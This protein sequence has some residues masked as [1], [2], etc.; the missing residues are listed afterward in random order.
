M[1][2]LKKL[3]SFTL[4]KTETIITNI[5]TKEKVDT[6][7]LNKLLSSDLLLE[8]LN[9]KYEG[10][11]YKNELKQL[12]EYKQK[13][14]SDGFIY[15]D[16]HKKNVY[17]R[18]HSKT[19]S[20][21]QLRKEIRQ[22]I[23][24]DIYVDIDI[25]NCHVVLLQQICK[26]NKQ[27]TP[28]L[29]DYIK[30]RN[31]H[32]L[33][34]MTDYNVDRD[35]AKKVFLVATYCGDFLIEGKP[36]PEF[37][38]KLVKETR[39]IAKIV[40]EK[41]P[42][43]KQMVIQLEK[44]KGKPLTNLNGKV[45]SHYL[46][47]V[48]HVILN[49]MYIY[50]VDNKFI[51]N[52]DCSLQA[53]GIMIPAITYN[54]D[55]LKKMSVHIKK[56]T[57]FNLTF[58]QKEMETHYCDII[59]DHIIDFKMPKF[60][61]SIPACNST[62]TLT[63][64][65][66]Y[67][68]NI[69]TQKMYND[70]KT[71]ILKSCC[72]TGKTY[73]VA[74]YTTGTDKKFLSIINRKSLLKAQ[75]KEFESHNIKLNN[76]EDKDNYDIKESGIICIN[77]IMKY[78]RVPASEF[79]NFIVYI[80]EINSLIET[81][82]HCSILTKDIKLV[83]QTL[84][85]IIQNAY[86]VI[87]SDH[88]INDNVFNLLQSRMTK[89]NDVA[90][91]VENTYQKFQGV[92]ATMIKQE[93]LFKNKIE[94]KM[95]NN[96][97]FWAG[98][99]SARTASQYF[100]NL[101]NLTQLDCILVTDETRPKIPND[102]SEWEGK[103]IFYSPKIETGI[104]FSVDTKQSVFYHMKGDS[105]LPTSSFQMA[106]RTRNM[107]DLTYY[108]KLK[109]DKKYKYTSL[110]DVKLKVKQSQ[111]ITNLYMN[112]SYLDIDDVMCMSE[113]SFFKIYCFNEYLKDIYEI[114]KAEHFK[115]ILYS[116]GFK[117]VE[118]LSEIPDTLEKQVITEM[119]EV[120]K[121]CT[122]EI[123]NKWVNGEVLNENYDIRKSILK[124]DNKADILT[125]KEYIFDKSKFEDHSKKI[126]LLKDDSYIR[127]KSNE[128]MINSYKEFGIHNIF[129]K[130]ELLSKYEKECKITRFNY[131]NAEPM[132]KDTTWN[133]IKKLFRKSTSKPE[134]KNDVIK[135]YV[136]IVNNIVK[137]YNSKR[138]QDK[139]V[140]TTEYSLSTDVINE[141]YNLDEISNPKRDSY[142]ELTLDYLKFKKPVQKE[143]KSKKDKKIKNSPLDEGL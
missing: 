135:E 119:K 25:E 54:S 117:C 80:D 1:E 93:E 18:S 138:S 59:D 118:D 72:G 76:Y 79:K 109:E 130:V 88:V 39:S 133:M 81:L 55:L 111:E 92:K 75:I 62:P 90:F 66:K 6:A 29:D 96:E 83:Y 134:N 49:Q 26:Q 78:S 68:S 91:F 129:S 104:D 65:S 94:E 47:E 44:E 115:F 35:Q 71:I 21:L 5:T 101:K 42:M 15:I 51:I 20:L 17:G 63:G 34:I 125:Y 140:R 116:N 10:R 112:C 87:V 114:N 56:V 86:K 43:I 8:K 32:L 45:L 22:T 36:E 31:Q 24:K 52:N 103:C 48:E 11:K 9:N 85:L 121:E 99:D 98:F 124:L 3:S 19:T 70:N 137:L 58:K 136:S 30:N 113:N 102:L 33:K 89:K 77:S 95:R 126:I 64:E 100:Y 14:N 107:K 82:T 69:F 61:R 38:S 142:D 53:D 74:K 132:I 139:G 28:Q 123:F 60:D 110:D 57:G 67:L 46:Q 128:L 73:S 27:K 131:N 37:Y 23:T 40:T 13:I 108:C 120:S 16:M 105:V 141:S 127:E 7:M 4:P 106:S 84:I 50:C 143:Y 97:G 2:Y 12:I 122:E 41:N